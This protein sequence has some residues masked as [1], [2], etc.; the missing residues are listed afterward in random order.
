MAAQNS[1]DEV[2]EHID[3]L[4][5]KTKKLSGTDKQELIS[6]I[7]NIEADRDK[8]IECYDE[9]SNATQEEFELRVDN[10]KTLNYKL[11]KS[12][13]AILI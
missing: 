12:I 9:L 13:D 4:K 11:Q 1:I 5:D 10:F 3:L 8:L 6:A 7:H 2:E